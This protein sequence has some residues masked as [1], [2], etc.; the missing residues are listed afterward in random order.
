[1]TVTDAAGYSAFAENFVETFVEEG[2]TLV[3]NQLDDIISCGVNDAF[4]LISVYP[5]LL[6]GEDP[7]NF[8]LTSSDAFNQTNA[9]D[10]P[11][12]YTVTSSPET[13]FVVVQNISNSC[14]S[15]EF[16]EIISQDCPITVDWGKDAVNK[17]YCYELNSADEY[18]YTITDGSPV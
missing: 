9:L 7:A 14:L 12:D 15:I 8:H 17:T 13:I 5:Q 16:F 18:R 3:T 11:K 4:D 6:G 2:E 10:I 1:V